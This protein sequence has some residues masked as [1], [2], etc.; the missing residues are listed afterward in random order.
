MAKKQLAL[1]LILTSLFTFLLRRVS[2]VGVFLRHNRGRSCSFR[3]PCLCPGSTPGLWMWFCK[4]QIHGN[5][6]ATWGHLGDASKDDNVSGSWVPLEVGRLFPQ[7]GLWNSLLEDV[8]RFQRE[9]WRPSL[10]GE[11]AQQRRRQTREWCTLNF[12]PLILQWRVSEAVAVRTRWANW[13][14]AQWIEWL[15]MVSHVLIST[16]LTHHD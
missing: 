8:P 1:M 5:R 13:P 4:L 6:D 15:S 16:A 14:L 12:N 9:G 7:H 2:R 3:G 11:S 10:Q